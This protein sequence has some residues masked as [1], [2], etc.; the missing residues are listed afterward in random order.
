[1]DTSEIYVKM[2]EAAKEIQEA[3]P[4]DFKGYKPLFNG[5]TY[6]ENAGDVFY[7]RGERKVWLPRQDQLQEML[8]YNDS[9][10]IWR[11]IDMFHHFCYPGRD[12][13]TMPHPCQMTAVESHELYIEHFTTMEQLW[14][15][16]VM[17]EKYGKKWNGEA[18]IKQ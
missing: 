8:Q 18:W 13:S 9:K 16:F 14:L 1:M 11:K 3:C 6:D 2:C 5:I 4:I 10:L 12:L 7:Y 17:Y 15:A